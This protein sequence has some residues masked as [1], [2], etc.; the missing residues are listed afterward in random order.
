MTGPQQI[1]DRWPQIQA[2]FA[3]EGVMISLTQALNVLP[4]LVS[5]MAGPV[6]PQSIPTIDL[7]AA[8]IVNAP[9]VRVWPETARI[10]KVSLFARSI[11]VSIVRVSV[12]GV[13]LF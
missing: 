4:K 11:L 7:A 5:A 8:R 10:S 1:A 9:D 13:E 3:S 2:A 6:P 12:R